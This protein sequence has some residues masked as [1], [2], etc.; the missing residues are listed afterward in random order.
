MN[1]DQPQSFQKIDRENMLGHIRNLPDQLNTA[2]QLGINSD[3]PA[4]KPISKIIVAGMGGS[5]IGADLLANYVRNAAAVPVFVSRDYNLPQW[6]RQPDVLLVA[7]SHSGSTEETLTAYQAAREYDVPRMVISTGGPLAE[8]ARGEGCPVWQFVHNGQPRSAVGFSFGLLLALLCRLDLVEPQDQAIRNALEAMKT[9]QARLE[10][11]QPVLKN[12][13]KQMAL[14][15][16]GKFP[17]I[18]GADLLSAV[19]RRWKGQINELAKHWAQAEELPEADHNL[20]A[21]TLY[22]RQLQT[23]LEAIFLGAPSLYE[24]NRIRVKLTCELLQ[25]KEIESMIFEAQGADALS[26][27]WTTLHFGD[28]LAYYMAMIKNVDPTPIHI[29]TGLKKA[30]QEYR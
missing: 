4:L 11:D 25:E 1:L 28:Y 13:A 6:A 30:L 15:L 16:S 18:F 5:A 20:L 9:Q 22:P 19:A 23:G 14:R 3:L 10:I 24:R 8:L 26:Q 29:M 7:S 21:G 17:V 2:W 27:L 12:P